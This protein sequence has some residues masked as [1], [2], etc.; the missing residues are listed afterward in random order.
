MGRENGNAIITDCEAERIVLGLCL[1]KSV[2]E[3]A[4]EMNVSKNIVYNIQ[5]NRSYVHIRPELRVKAKESVR[6][7]QNEKISNALTLYRTGLF[8]QNEIAKTLHISRNTLR[9]EIARCL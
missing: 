7:M 3:I 8:S 5:Q 9:R 4:S 1:G 2:N 6:E